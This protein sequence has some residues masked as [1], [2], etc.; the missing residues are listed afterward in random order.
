MKKMIVRLSGGLGNQ[1]FQ[2]SLARSMSHK[3]DKDVYIGA[4]SYF[5]DRKRHYDLNGYKLKIK[6]APL[7]LDFF[8][9]FMFL[10]LGKFAISSKLVS[11]EDGWFKYDAN[12]FETE[13]IYLCGCWQNLNYFE[14]IRDELKEE[15]ILTSKMTDEQLLIKKLVREKES[16]AVHIRR[17]DYLEA[18]TSQI[19]ETQSLD[20]YTDAINDIRSKVT[21]P[22]FCVFSDDI[23]WCKEHFKHLDDV[24]FPGQ[25]SAGDAL[26][27]FELMK[28][29][30]HFIISNSTFS[31]WASWLGKNDDSIIIYPQKWFKDSSDNELCRDALFHS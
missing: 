5:R 28:N 15:I 29:C 16:V 12:I 23:E 3:V 27:E 17:G 1:L 25:I 8:C 26:V 24:V 20:Y 10:L 13:A 11:K 2:Y 4:S 18:L 22:L 9:E 7:W 31:W 6:R 19:Y 21:N 30:H 14:D